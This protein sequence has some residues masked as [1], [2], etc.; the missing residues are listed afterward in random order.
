MAELP[1]REP[2]YSPDRQGGGSVGDG[3][4]Q[5]MGGGQDR[6]RPALP[7]NR[8]TL[9][10]VASILILCGLAA[11]QLRATAKPSD[12]PLGRD[13]FGYLRQ[14]ALFRSNGIAGIDT[15]LMPAVSRP[16]IA[17]AKAIGE[18][19]EAWREAIAPHCHHYKPGVDKIVLQYPPGTGFLLSLLPETGATRSLLL[20][21]V[22][23]ILAL[24]VLGM[25]V[26]PTLA[27]ALPV[28]LAGYV[29]VA[30]IVRHWSS[31]SVGPAIVAAVLAGALSAV[32]FAGKR[33]TPFILLGLIGLGAAIRVAN[34]WLATGAIVILAWEFL[35]RPSVPAFVRGLLFASALAIGLVPLFAADLINAG[36]LFATTYS[37]ADARPPDFSP[38]ILWQAATV[39]LVPIL[40]GAAAFLP[41]LALPQLR[42]RATG[43]MFITFGL[44]VL[45]LLTHPVLVNYY[46]LPTVAFVIGG[47]LAN[48]L[49]IWRRS[50]TG[51]AVWWP[52]LAGVAAIVVVGIVVLSSGVAGVRAEV[53]PAVKS[54]LGPKTLVWADMYSGFF[55]LD[56]NQYAA[57]LTFAAPE[58]QDR[59]VSGL[60]AAGWDE[61][62]MPDSGRMRL[63]MARLQPAYDFEP[64]GQAFGQPVFRMRLKP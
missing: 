22:L 11:I 54:A 48:A 55:V 21:S 30:A 50:M 29:M 28:S 5:I 27:T 46:M 43:S 41:C 8:L 36:S 40:I 15:E 2:L 64:L 63:A 37:P 38:A 7:A 62:F 42:N 52:A 31:F 58:T 51:P 12:E 26:A 47:I 13:W 33:W 10:K 24:A 1:C 61:L 14:A 23:A 20:A 59:L 60:S 57:K 9:T 34:V 53:E 4:H 6:L 3:R 49:V 32:A 56:A 39:Y 16:L 19:A 18:P 35:R 17:I 44:S 25:A 45:F